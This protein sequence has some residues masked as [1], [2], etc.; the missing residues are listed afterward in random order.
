MQVP[1]T[2]NVTQMH[3]G[4][5]VLVPRDRDHSC[6]FLLTPKGR[7]AKGPVLEKPVILPG[8]KLMTTRWR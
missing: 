3:K 1:I 4:S 5:W 2:P 8:I 7:P 6:T